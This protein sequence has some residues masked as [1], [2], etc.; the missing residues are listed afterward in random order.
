MHDHLHRCQVKRQNPSTTIKRVIYQPSM[1]FHCQHTAI[2]QTQWTQN[3]S[4]V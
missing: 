3:H 2:N 4:V 1:K